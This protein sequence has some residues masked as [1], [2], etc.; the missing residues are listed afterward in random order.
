MTADPKKDPNAK[1]IPEIEVNELIQMDLEDLPVE[2]A[3]LDNL[4]RAR[5]VR[6][7]LLVNGRKPGDLTRA[8]NN[9][10]PGTRIYRA[11]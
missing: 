2:R 4:S 8:L 9:E 7:V 3:M 5:S 10:N 1:F 6:E 11:G